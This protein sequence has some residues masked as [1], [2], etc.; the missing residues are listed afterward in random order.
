M[1]W[2]LT[3]VCGSPSS[4]GGR[5]TSRISKPSPPH[6]L[7]RLENTLSF[8][9]AIVKL[10]RSFVVG[11]SIMHK[12][13]T[14]VDRMNDKIQASNATAATKTASTNFKTATDTFCDLLQAEK[15]DLAD[16][17]VGN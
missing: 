16:G 2:P 13:C 6:T 1:L 15:E 4:G 8:L 11:V 10:Y 14:L 9:S 5:A 3:T 12:V 17:Q 7:F